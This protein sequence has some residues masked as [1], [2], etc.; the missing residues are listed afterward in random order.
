MLYDTI[1]EELKKLNQWVCT[2]ENSKLPMKAWEKRAA[3]SID[4][5]TWADFNTAFESVKLRIYDYCGFVFANNGIVGI[6]IDNAYDDDSFINATGIDIISSCRSYTEKS[7][8]G[9][10]FHILLRGDLPFSGKNNLK[11]VE[12]YKTA[13]YFIMTGNTFLYSDIIDNQQAIDHVL[14][15]YFP[16]Q[17]LATNMD[18]PSMCREQSPNQANMIAFGWIRNYTPIWTDCQKN[19][20]IK[21]RPTYPD[22]PV[23]CRN[24]C[25]TSLAGQLHAQGYSKLQIYKEISFVNSTACSSPLDERELQRICN[26]ITRYER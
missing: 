26:S 8:S 25:L 1:P 17:G 4:P 2:W 6:D 11:G 15:K 23:G 20:R 3:S 12:I 22:I 19:G 5:T 7:R 16:E 13:R 10:G 9:K 18:M 21:I 14:E 24:T